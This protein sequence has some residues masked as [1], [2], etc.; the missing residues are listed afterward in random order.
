[1]ACPARLQVRLI[2]AGQA[3]AWALRAIRATGRSVALVGLDDFELADM[4]APGVTVVTQAPYTLGV[5]AAEQ[6]FEC[7]SVRNWA[8]YPELPA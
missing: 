1:M 3:F 7:L 6:L 4:I 8:A 2:L 5:R